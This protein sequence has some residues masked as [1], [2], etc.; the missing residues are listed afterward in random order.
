MD[1]IAKLVSLASPEWPSCFK[2][3]LNKG[4]AGY[5]F[6]D[7]PLVNQINAT[8]IAGYLMEVVE[9]PGKVIDFSCGCGVLLE[10]L[11]YCG[12]SVQGT[13][14]PGSLYSVYLNALQIPFITLDG[15]ILP[16]PFKNSSVDYVTQV[17]ALDFLEPTLWPS[18]L[19]EY[20]RI[21]RKMVYIRVN[22]ESAFYQNRHFLDDFKAEG[23]SLVLQKKSHY[24]WKVDK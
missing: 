3:A 18:I 13:E 8:T 4:W 6:L 5:S 20:T 21:A 10:I 11:H 23:W 14:P 19:R 2:D 16:Y 24:K 17:N 9:T 7:K 1:N 12:C 22:P 15:N